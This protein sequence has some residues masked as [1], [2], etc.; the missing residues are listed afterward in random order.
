MLQAL[1]SSGVILK[2]FQNRGTTNVSK[3]CP[4]VNKISEVEDRKVR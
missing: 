4:S 1:K 2:V 3:I